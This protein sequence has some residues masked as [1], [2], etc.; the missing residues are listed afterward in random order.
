M[1]Y[2]GAGAVYGFAAG[3]ASSSSG[4]AAGAARGSSNRQRW[5][6]QHGCKKKRGGG[7]HKDWYERW[8]YRPHP[9]ADPTDVGE[10]S[11]CWRMCEFVGRADALDL[12]GR[13]KEGAN[14]FPAHRFLPANFFSRRLAAKQA[15]NTDLQGYTLSDVLGSAATFLYSLPLPRTFGEASLREV[16]S[17]TRL[18]VPEGNESDVATLGFFVEWKM[19]QAE[20]IDLTETPLGTT[21]RQTAI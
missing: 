4:G 18:T 8:F 21:I 19:S 15:Y 2:P 13:F 6:Q 10:K 17:K 20:D 12:I 9:V 3:A 1:V 7:V 16:L 14:P 5:Q 11:S